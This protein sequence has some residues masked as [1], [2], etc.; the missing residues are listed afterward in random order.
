MMAVVGDSSGGG[1]MQSSQ[2]NLTS[3]YLRLRPNATIEPLTVAEDFWHT[4]ASGALG[5]FHDEYLVTLHKIDVDFPMWEMH[6]NGDEI[7]CL[8]S[9]KMTITLD[10]DGQQTRHLLDESGAFVLVPKGAWHTATVHANV[11]ALFITAG[12]GTEHRERN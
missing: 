12:E 1:I 8:L 5:S 9:G 11:R 4:I 7:I 10:V 3:T 6:P 2:P